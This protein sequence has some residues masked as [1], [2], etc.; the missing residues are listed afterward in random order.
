MADTVLEV[1]SFAGKRHEMPAEFGAFAGL[2]YVKALQHPHALAP[3]ARGPSNK[4]GIKVGRHACV[5]VS[6]VWEKRAV[7]PVD[8]PRP[9]PSPRPH[10]NGYTS[11]SC[12]HAQRDRRKL[13][14]EPLHL[15]PEGIRTLTEDVE[16]GKRRHRPA[17]M[18]CAPTSGGGKGGGG[19]GLE[20]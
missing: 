20:F 9:H 8:T 18:L 10:N 6:Y 5:C 12:M 16:R 14:I 19:E 15:P 17:A 7:E 13:R 2:L 3:T 11:P 4:M 1:D